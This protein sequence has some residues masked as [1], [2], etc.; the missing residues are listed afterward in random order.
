MN[1]HDAPQEEGLEE[2]SQLEV[3]LSGKIVY[4]VPIDFKTGGIRIPGFQIWGNLIMGCDVALA[5]N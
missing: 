2:D 5:F 4:P 1:F 3:T